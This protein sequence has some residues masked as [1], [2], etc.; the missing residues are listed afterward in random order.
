MGESGKSVPAGGPGTINGVLYQLL[1][2][3][4]TL[5]GLRATDQRIVDDRLDSIT[6]IVEPS[7]GAINK[8]FQ[9][10]NAW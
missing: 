9:M 8:R 3:L 6:L 10:K 1:W 2:S 4:A 7:G 5:G